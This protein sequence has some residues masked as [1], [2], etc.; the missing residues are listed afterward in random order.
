MAIFTF[1]N[2]ISTTLA[3]AVAPSDTSLTLSSSAGLPASI[4][5]GMSLVITLNDQATRD[6]FEVIYAGAVSGA[7]LSN[8]SRGQ[9]G[10]SALAWLTGDFAF[11]GP[12]AG[13][14]QSFGQLAKD[15][16]WTGSNSFEQSVDVTGEVTAT[17]GF[18]VPHNT[19]SLGYQLSSTFGP[20][21]AFFC[22]PTNQVMIGNTSFPF[23][24][25]GANGGNV[26]GI[27][28]TQITVIR[29][30]NTPF[31]NNT[32]APIMVSA[33]TSSTGTGSIG[34]FING[35]EFTNSS[36]T[37][38]GQAL[39]VWAIVMP[40]STYQYVTTGSVSPTAT[41]TEIR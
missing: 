35:V 18:L 40:G 4:P 19:S 1:A 36:A 31:V 17:Q 14:Q 25:R 12:T 38:S 5:A 9:E 6:N 20:F 15:N 30:Y 37:S 13:Q 23:F 27:G 33:A 32:P 24:I 26:F 2:N 10:T 41:F 11:S 7:T 3:G 8:L 28:Q 21:S 39:C 16:D 34:I 29:T 22:S